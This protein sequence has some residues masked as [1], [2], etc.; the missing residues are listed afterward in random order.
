VDLKT[1]RAVRGAAKES[2][3]GLNPV[4]EVQRKRL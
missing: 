2:S 3:T 1:G 4:C